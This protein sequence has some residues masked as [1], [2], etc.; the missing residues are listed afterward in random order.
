MKNATILALQGPTGRS[1]D[2]AP[3]IDAAFAQAARLSVLHVGPIPLLPVY[4]IGAAPYA[5]PYAPDDWVTKRNAMLETLAAKQAETR[6]LLQK[7]GLTG[8][9][10]TLCVEPSAMHSLVAIRAVFADYCVVQHSLRADEAA[11]ENIIYGLLF[12]S[13]TP[14]LLNTEKQ[15]D[16]LAPDNIMIAW[17]SSL[18]AARAVR[19]ALPI[20]KA[21]KE[22]TIACFD[23][24]TTKWADGEN[25][26]ADLASWLSHHGCR[27]TVQEYASGGKKISSAILARAEECDA[28][29]VVMGAYGRS[30]LN[31]RFFG[32]TTRSMI[33][34]EDMPVLM[35][36]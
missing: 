11:F 31:E 14:L 20:L 26:G 17:N 22:V 23:P 35:A 21:A 1:A 19:S 24:D 12:E 7:Q 4:S 15:N 32:G 30:R 5:V 18:P 25:P 36:H 16:A 3:V 27:V 29:L 34:Q 33:A 13:P 28:D 10:A 2:L 9:V 6:E 8:E